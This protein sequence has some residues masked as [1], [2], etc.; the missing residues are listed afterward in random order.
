MPD[1]SKVIDQTKRYTL[2]LQFGSWAYHRKPPSRRNKTSG[3]ERIMGGCR[4]DGCIT[5]PRNSRMKEMSLG[6]GRMEA[7]FEESQGPEGAVAPKM[8][9][10]T[11]KA[12]QN[13]CLMGR[14]AMLFGK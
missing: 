11:D 7:S 2:V 6:E 3:V 9:G 10:W 5:D 12:R 14:D 1:S 13:Y 4:P 8:D